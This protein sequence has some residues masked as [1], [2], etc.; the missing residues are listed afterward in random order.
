MMQRTIPRAT[1]HVAPLAALLVC[2]FASVPAQAEQDPLVAARLA[3]VDGDHARCAE[4]ADQGRKAKGASW[5]AHNVFASC[6]ALDAQKRKSELGAEKYE[7]RMLTAIETIEFL[8]TGDLLPSVRERLKF[9]QIAVDM[10]K[11]LAADLAAMQN[12]GE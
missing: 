2:V 9:S 5:Q 11:Q 6:V 3:A 7:A 4:L 10:R 12:A 1:A 8:I